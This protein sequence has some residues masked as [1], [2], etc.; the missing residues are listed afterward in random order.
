MIVSPSEHLEQARR[1]LAH[2]GFLLRDHASEPTCVQWA[3]TAAF[4]CAVHCIQ[5]HLIRHHKD[6]RTHVSRADL[7]AD[8]AYGVPRDVQAA[9]EWLKQRSEAARYRLAEFGPTWVQ[10]RVLG[11]RLERVTQFVGL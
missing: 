9:Y 6:P 7:I 2:A 8:P 3:V 1:N 11:E 10:R 4:Y 5:A